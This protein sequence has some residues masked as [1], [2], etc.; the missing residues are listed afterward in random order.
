MLRSAIAAGEL[1]AHNNLGTLLRDGGALIEAQQEFR[2]GARGGD[3][4][5][6]RNLADLRSTHRRQLNR[7]YRRR[8]RER[9]PDLPADN[10]RQAG[11]RRDD[12]AT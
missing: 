11:G 10:K 2:F 7:A 5:A 3:E 12:G 1:H 6:S 4:L 8:A 9:G